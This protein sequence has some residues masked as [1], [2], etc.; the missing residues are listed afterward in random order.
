MCQ[1]LSNMKDSVMVQTNVPNLIVAESYSS[2]IHSKIQ[3]YLLRAHFKAPNYELKFSFRL[4]LLDINLHVSPQFDKLA[5]FQLFWTSYVVLVH[6]FINNSRLLI[7]RGIMAF[8][9]FKVGFEYK[10]VR[11][12]VHCFSIV[13]FIRQ[14]KTDVIN[15]PVKTNIQE[16]VLT[17]SIHVKT[18]G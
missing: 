14:L 10:Y 11:R 1:I 2:E 13:Y 6:F 16:Y 7:S 9:L 4:L 17:A 12:F 3:L 8:C 18:V 15:F 5:D